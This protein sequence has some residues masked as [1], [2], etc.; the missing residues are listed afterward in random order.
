MNL[1]LSE[2][3][4]SATTVINDALHRT[5][6]TGTQMSTTFSEATAKT[7]TDMSTDDDLD[8]MQFIADCPSSVE[9]RQQGAMCL[10]KVNPSFEPLKVCLDDDTSIEDGDEEMFDDDAF[11]FDDEDFKALWSH[12]TLKRISVPLKSHASQNRWTMAPASEALAAQV[13]H[14]PLDHDDS[15]FSKKIPVQKIHCHPPLPHRT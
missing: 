5:T 10:G 6:R 8:I 14:A 7:L 2:N 15:L 4:A 11:Y 9:V 1:T 12:E 13:S 3:D